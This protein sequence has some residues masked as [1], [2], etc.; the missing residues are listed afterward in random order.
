M[1]RHVIVNADDFG[2]SSGI[3]RGIVEAHVRGVVTST[4]LMVT[5]SGVDEAVAMSR[6]LPRLGIGLHW[7]VS[8]EGESARKF[9]LENPALVRDEFARQLDRFVQLVGRL[10]THVDSHQH[11][12]RLAWVMPVIRPLVERLGVPLRHDGKVSFVGGFYGQWEHLVT[13]LSHVSVSY[14]QQLLRE[15]TSAEW[16]EIA[17]HPGY[18]SDDFT[19]VY[20]AEREHELRTLCDPRVR[21]TIE[22]LGLTLVNYDHWARLNAPARRAEVCPWG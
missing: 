21:R 16:T 15:E 1:N 6:D 17:C 10:P 8:G 18:A 4:S 7:D 2:A 5:G 9:D 3:N 20:L 22:E 11:V 19:S 14:I 12:H 13:D